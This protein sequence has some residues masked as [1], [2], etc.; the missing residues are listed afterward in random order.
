M[1]IDADADGIFAI[2]MALH[3]DPD[4]KV[5]PGLAEAPII[6]EPDRALLEQK[7]GKLLDSRQAVAFD[8]AGR[9]DQRPFDHHPP[10]DYPDEC[11]IKNVAI[12]TR[13]YESDP[14]V[15]AVADQA[16]HWDTRGGGDIFATINRRFKRLRDNP[17]WRSNPEYRLQAV[18]EALVLARPLFD[19]WLYWAQQM[20][21][22]GLKAA[23]EAGTI[24]AKSGERGCIIEHDS[25]WARDLA[26]KLGLAIICQITSH[27]EIAV[28]PNRRLEG[29]N[30][31]G[32]LDDVLRIL[33]SDIARPRGYRY[34]DDELLAPG[35]I[36]GCEEV[37]FHA[38]GAEITVGGNDRNI[39]AKPDWD[40]DYYLKIM[41][42]AVTLALEPKR[43]PQCCPGFSGQ[44]GCIG[45]ECGIYLANLPRCRS[46]GRT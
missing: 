8:C 27:G 40:K 16:A 10:E 21:E 20:Q 17:L 36:A 4:G 39:G 24:V 35:T 44:H 37:Y 31:L 23:I 43:F 45:A 32:M 42:V 12:V 15:R 46:Q 11:A 34:S 28:R 29:V 13:K 41:R 26:Q 25:L 3:C 18:Q 38:R 7:Y 2:L 14:V 6:V 30:T 5:F 33:R 9:T 22:P 19:D 1:I